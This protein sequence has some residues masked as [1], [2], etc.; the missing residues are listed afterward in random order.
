[1][2]KNGKVKKGVYSAFRHT[3][4]VRRSGSRVE[5][6]GCERAATSGSAVVQARIGRK[7]PWKNVATI[8]V[9]ALGYFDRKVRVA[10]AGSKQF[11]YAFGTSHSR[12][13][14]AAG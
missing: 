2:F 5:L 1:R 6:F 11:R 9:N 10:G 3:F 8:P 7:G 12:V 4:Y 14:K 13:V